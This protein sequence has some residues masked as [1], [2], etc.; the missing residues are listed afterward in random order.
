MKRW[1]G[2]II[3]AISAVFAMPVYA[4]VND[5]YFDDFT[6]DYYLIKDTEGV[7]HLKVVE[8]VT[9]VF[10]DFNQN[11]GICRQ[12]P[13]TNQGGANITLPN[14]NRLNMTLSRNGEPEPIYSI[15]KNKDYFEVCTGDETYVLGKQVYTFE[16][17]FEKVV[18]DFGEYQELYW[19][20]NGGGAKQKFN[21]VTARLHFDENTKAAY[22]GKQWCYVGK[23]GANDQGRCEIKEIDDGLEF[24]ANNLTAHENLTFDAELKPGSFVVPEPEVSYAYVWALIAMVVVCAGIIIIWPLRKWLAMR[25]KINYYKGFFVKPEYQPNAKYNLLEMAEVYLGKKKDAKVAMLL[26]LIVQRKV[27]LIKGEGKNWKIKVNNLDGTEGTSVKLLEILNGGNSVNVGDEIV[28][29]RRA[30]T[31]KLVSLN[32]ALER[33]VVQSLKQDK[34]VEKGYSFVGARNRHGFS[35]IITGLIVYGMLTIYFGLMITSTIYKALDND[36]MIM[37]LKDEFVPI[38]IC[39]MAITVAICVI[40]VRVRRKYDYYTK[41]GLEA[42]RYM[43]GLKLYIGMVETERLKFLQS[44][45]NVDMSADGIVKLYEKLLPYAAVF[46]LEESWMKELEQYCR[47]E[48]IE[49]P[50]WLVTG[51][52]A[53]EISR[54]TRNAAG[55]AAASSVMASSGS[56]ISGGGGWSSSSSGGG[57]GGFSGGGGGG[58][59]FSGR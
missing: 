52:T 47:V 40:L 54:I 4:D 42:S 48:E 45:K 37:A 30:A 20:T 9:V 23:Y 18:T 56:G 11:K 55:Y 51:I 19:D 33:E 50:D 12:I 59:G 58:G 46:G 41:L 43:D 26:E 32:R 1:F 28:V 35:A 38:A 5:F 22:A 57:G 29:K 36:Y 10:P 34:L 31:S 39:I 49:E 24:V 53:S 17:E 6:G 2:L 27:S 7:S 8:N 13:F 21:K 44:V 14:L 16:Y 15:E 25:E 3:I